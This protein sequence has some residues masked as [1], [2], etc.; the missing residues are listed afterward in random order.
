MKDKKDKTKKDKNDKFPKFS[1][2]KKEATNKNLEFEKPIQT[3]IYKC[4]NLLVDSIAASLTGISLEDPFKSA[5]TGLYFK[6][7][8]KFDKI[9]TDCFFIRMTRGVHL[10]E[11]LIQ[12]K[13][14]GGE[15]AYVLYAEEQLFYI[16]NYSNV[17]YLPVTEKQCKSISEIFPDESNSLQPASLTA[18]QFIEGLTT[19][20]PPDLIDEFGKLFEP[21]QLINEARDFFST[22]RLLSQT[23]FLPIEKSPAWIAFRSL[24]KNKFINNELIDLVAG[25]FTYKIMSFWIRKCVSLGNWDDKIK[26]R[27]EVISKICSHPNEDLFLKECKTRL[28]FEINKQMSNAI[29]EAGKTESEKVDSLLA[30]S[31]N[32]YFKLL[33]PQSSKICSHEVKK[34]RDVFDKALLKSELSNPKKST[35]SQGENSSQS[36]HYRLFRSKSLAKIKTG[37]SKESLMES[38]STAKTVS[39]E[40]LTSTIRIA[41][42]NKSITNALDPLPFPSRR[43]ELIIPDQLQLKKEESQ[44]SISQ[45][46]RYSPRPFS[47]SSGTEDLTE[48]TSNKNSP[49]FQQSQQVYSLKLSGQNISGEMNK[50]LF[51]TP[52]V[53]IIQLSQSKEAKEDVLFFF[54]E[55][56]VKK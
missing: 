13:V 19:Y 42:S 37:R 9:I 17:K 11:T 55:S 34:A 52:I 25:S 54:P 22:V 36:S 8:D 29:L 33:W 14:R 2:N 23:L 4:S 12:H 47:K 15:A 50:E 5:H 6:E 49:M 38:D 48:E 56:T 43:R 24:P 20:S 21:L 7:N 53:P 46:R 44:I 45:S 35:E 28:Q 51:F 1:L 27:F 41:P 39:T 40:I 30:V 18:Q 26:Q 16:D 32:I 10:P 31:D 3:W